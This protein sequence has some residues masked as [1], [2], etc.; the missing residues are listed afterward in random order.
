MSALAQMR[1]A[2]QNGCVLQVTDPDGKQI[3]T[4]R[5]ATLSSADDPEIPARLSEWRNRHV[6]LFLTQYTTTPA[7]T[8]RWLREV[9]P[10]D[11]QR[12]LFLIYN[13]DD[14]LVSVA[15]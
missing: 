15:I 8:A 12:I 7:R 5:T 14:A 10:R 6:S 9:L 1:R 4:L 11:D 3:A 13:T 2:K